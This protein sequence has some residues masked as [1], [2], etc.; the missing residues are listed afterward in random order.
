MIES[1]A[2]ADVLRECASMPQD[3]EGIKW[4]HVALEVVFARINHLRR[5][6]ELAIESSSD[7]DLSNKQRKRLAYFSIECRNEIARLREAM[8]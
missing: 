2:V 6:E 4:R 1:S 8:K 5:M 3:E 7:P